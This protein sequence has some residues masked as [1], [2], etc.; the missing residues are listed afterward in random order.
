MR[1]YACVCVCIFSV[2]VLI[3][4]GLSQN[5]A[6]VLDEA[7]VLRD[8]HPIRPRGLPNVLARPVVI[9]REYSRELP[10]HGSNAMRTDRSKED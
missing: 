7:I 6:E 4:A 2:N 5:L 8:I 1:V 10:K 3:T 9:T